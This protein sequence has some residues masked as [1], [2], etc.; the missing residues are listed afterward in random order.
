MVKSTRKVDLCYIGKPTRSL[1]KIVGKDVYLISNI[2]TKDNFS[3]DYIVF[4]EFQKNK[5]SYSVLEKNKGLHYLV[6]K[7]D[8][9][10]YNE[11]FSY[12]PIDLV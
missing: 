4:G 10:S 12:T 5:D 2:E 1:D 6:Q 3:C 11:T 8:V 7:G 9:I